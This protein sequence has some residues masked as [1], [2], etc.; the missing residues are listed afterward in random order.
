MDE[1]EL[2][3]RQVLALVLHYLANGGGTKVELI[4]LMEGLGFNPATVARWADRRLGT[5][6]LNRAKPGIVKGRDD[7]Y[8]DIR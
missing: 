8:T 7:E 2:E 4:K 1:K 5:G 3:T 6:P